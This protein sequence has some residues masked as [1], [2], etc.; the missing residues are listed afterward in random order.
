[1]A[2]ILLLVSMYA[3]PCLLAGCL[4]LLPNNEVLLSLGSKI[5]TEIA[6]KQSNSELNLFERYSLVRKYK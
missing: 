6:E 4:K 2:Y 3:D 1:M 5:I